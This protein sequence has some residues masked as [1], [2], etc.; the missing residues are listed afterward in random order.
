MP[1]CEPLP[2]DTRSRLAD[3]LEVESLVGSRGAGASSRVLRLFDALGDEGHD[4]ELDEVTGDDLETEILEEKRASCA[5]EVLEELGHRVDVLGS[6]YPFRLDLDDVGSRWKIMPSPDTSDDQIMAARVC[7]VFC[8]LTSAFRDNRICG[9]DSSSLK[10]A[11]E[12]HFQAVAVDAA[13]GIM[14]GEAISF[15]WPRKSGL[16]FLPALKDACQ[17]LRLGSPL[18]IGPLWSQGQEKDAG[19]DVIAWRDFCDGRPG[20]LVMLGQVA[21]GRNWAEKSVTSHTDRFFL[22]FTEAPTK[23]FIPSIFIPFPQHHECRGRSGKVFE[24]VAREEA[25]AREVSFGLVVDRLRIVEAAAA[26]LAAH[27][28]NSGTS[29]LA[30]L[31]Q[32]VA[33]QHLTWHGQRRDETTSPSFDL[34]IFRNV[35]S[36]VR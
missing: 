9:T 17:R 6:R 4:I 1:I 26:R 15:G 7:Y 14:N 18:E 19:I 23:H 31:N 30:T 5:D 2:N 28:D 22:W 3:W 27:G 12:E 29:T 24:D 20:K 25:W 36:A 16:G 34:P 32:W 21:S 13:A 8:L 10:K 33:Q 11:T 35:S